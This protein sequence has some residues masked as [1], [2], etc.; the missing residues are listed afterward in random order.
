MTGLHGCHGHYDWEFGQLLTCCL[1]CGLPSRPQP[2]I[3]CQCVGYLQLLSS[4][5]CRVL[6]SPCAH[7]VCAAASCDLVD[8]YSDCS[9]V[10]RWTCSPF[11][12]TW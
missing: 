1:T 3:R 9:H 10:V 5:F 12:W 6:H 8:C 4:A 2:S 7:R 11:S